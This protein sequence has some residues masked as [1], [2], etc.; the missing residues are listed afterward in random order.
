MISN[1]LDYLV[2]KGFRTPLVMEEAP[3]QIEA[4][5]VRIIAS[6][7]S[8]AWDARVKRNGVDFAAKRKTSSSSEGVAIQSPKEKRRHVSLW[9][10]LW[11]SFSAR[12]LF[13]SALGLLFYLL[14]YAGPLLIKLLVRHVQDPSEE[15]WKGFFYATLL[16]I[17]TAVGSLINHQFLRQQV[18][19]KCV[20]HN[21]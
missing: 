19:H 5:D 13:G 1:R 3:N 2:R 21:A 7:F 12:F 14:T 10:Q 15:A 9:L 4:A 20:I 8:A 18:R 17:C 6:E 11:S 16:F